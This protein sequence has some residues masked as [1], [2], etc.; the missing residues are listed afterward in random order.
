MLA[1]EGVN[2]KSLIS[3]LYHK[4]LNVEKR[5]YPEYPRD[6]FRVYQHYEDVI[7]CTFNSF[8]HRVYPEVAE[9]SRYSDHEKWLIDNTCRILLISNKNRVSGRNTDTSVKKILKFVNSVIVNKETR[10]R[11]N[12]RVFDYNLIID[13]SD[14]SPDEVVQIMMSE[15]GETDNVTKVVSVE[16]G[17]A[18]KYTLI[19]DEITVKTGNIQSLKLVSK[20]SETV[21]KYEVISLF[22]K[23][24][25][26]VGLDSEFVPEDS[27]WIAYFDK[28]DKLCMDEW[29]IPPYKSSNYYKLPSK[30]KDGTPLD[31]Q[32][33]DWGVA[34]VNSRVVNVMTYM[35]V[36]E[37]ELTKNI[38]IFKKNVPKEKQ[39]KDYFTECCNNPIEMAKVKYGSYLLTSVGKP[40][41]DKYGHKV[42]GFP[43][44]IIR[45]EAFT[46]TY[47]PDGKKYSV[48]ETKKM[49]VEEKAFFKSEIMGAI[50]KSRKFKNSKI[51]LNWLQCT[52][53]TCCVDNRIEFVF[54]IKDGIRELAEESEQEKELNETA[55]FKG[56]EEVK[57]TEE[58]E[59]E[60]ELDETAMFK[61][62][63][64]VKSTEET[65]K[66]TGNFETTS[67]FG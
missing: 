58:S 30:A 29:H 60:K 51:P 32:L 16:S 3:L 11:G 37:N 27:Y 61:D 9:N 53:I 18:R 40:D 21:E 66:A 15:M 7:L 59:Q 25:Q 54:E 24:R 4:G 13:I 45:I 63:E 28:N 49:F 67:L 50:K 17:F 65:K 34:S 38:L 57:S 55:M 20:E 44:D 46:R 64:K 52:K 31:Y 2:I 1:I 33:D 5:S 23:R 8:P 19:T 62:K 56:K 43:F 42:T 36:Y 47:G 12:E 41:F 6:P 22:N 14:L 10:Y 35:S 39:T 26:H 48:K